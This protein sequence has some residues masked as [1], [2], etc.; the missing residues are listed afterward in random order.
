VYDT[1]REGN[2][3]EGQS[4]MVDLSIHNDKFERIALIEFN[5]L[6]SFGLFRKLVKLYS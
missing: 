5:A 6:D 4:A 1:Q 2:G 3:K